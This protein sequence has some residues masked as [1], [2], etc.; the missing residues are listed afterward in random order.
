ME[1]RAVY[2]KKKKKNILKNAPLTTVLSLIWVD[3]LNATTGNSCCK[4]W[5]HLSTFSFGTRSMTEKIKFN[6]THDI[7]VH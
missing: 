4:H 2:I 1:E 6:K 3:A 5:I 7:S